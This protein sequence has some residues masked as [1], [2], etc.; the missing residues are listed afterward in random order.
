MVKG[1]LMKNRAWPVPDLSKQGDQSQRQSIGHSNKVLQIQKAQLNMSHRQMEQSLD[2]IFSSIAP[3]LDP[4]MPTE[5]A[6]TLNL[7][8]DVDVLGLM[9]QYEDL[10]HKNEIQNEMQS[11]G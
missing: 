10:L 8:T 5:T 9:K 7:P 1:S 6:E 3:K 11:S 2:E 4:T